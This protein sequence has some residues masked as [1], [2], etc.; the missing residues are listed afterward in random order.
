VSAQLRLIQRGV[1]TSKNRYLT[2]LLCMQI[3]D[4][5]KREF[6]TIDFFF[7]TIFLLY[8]KDSKN[9]MF[10][11]QETV[12]RLTELFNLYVTKRK[13]KRVDYSKLLDRVDKLH[14]KGAK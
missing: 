10:M 3:M 5:D 6:K 13:V 7:R 11:V 2:R 1:D 4:D 14:K 12:S 8:T 9:S